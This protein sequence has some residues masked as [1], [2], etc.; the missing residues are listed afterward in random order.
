MYVSRDVNI[1]GKKFESLETHIRVCPPRI[2]GDSIKSVSNCPIGNPAYFEYSGM[3]YDTESFHASCPAL[4][5]TV[6]CDF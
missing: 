1:M 6:V 5:V 4:A 2:G 3:I